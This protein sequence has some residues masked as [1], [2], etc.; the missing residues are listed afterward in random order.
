MAR[1]RPGVEFIGLELRRYLLEK[2]QAI[3]ASEALPNVH[4]YL[5][6]VKEHLPILFDPN[7]LSRVYIHFPDPWTRRRRH[8]KRRMVDA[9][10]VETLH[11][12]LKTGG[13]VHAM[14]DKDEVGGEILALFEAHGG[15]ENACGSGRFCNESTTGIRTREE[16]YYIERGDRIFR[17]KFVHRMPV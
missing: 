15:Y 3:L 4:V 5:A 7:M 17:L 16:A 8:H 9:H 2:M 11:V 1:R 13:E 14:T 6:N 10:L 12:L